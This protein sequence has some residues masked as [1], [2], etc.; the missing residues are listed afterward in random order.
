MSKGIFP[1]AYEGLLKIL[2]YKNKASITSKVKTI[3]A[4]AN[5]I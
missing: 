5:E 4:F 3:P 2:N 1:P